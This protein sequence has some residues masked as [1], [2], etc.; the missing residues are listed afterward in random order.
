MEGLK[1]GCP[2]FCPTFVQPKLHFPNH[3][4]TFLEML[5]KMKKRFVQ[6]FV[7]VLDKTPPPIGGRCVLSNCPM[8]NEEREEEV[9]Y[10]LPSWSRRGRGYS[11]LFMVDRK[12]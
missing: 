11:A 8:S 6:R 10:N 12:R 5:D 3:K 7:Q 4:M 2:T 9:R 1:R